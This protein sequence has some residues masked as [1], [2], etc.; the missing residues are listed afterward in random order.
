LLGVVAAAVDTNSQQVLHEG[1]LRPR[2][3]LR[4]RAW[5][6]QRLNHTDP[7]QAARRRGCSAIPAAVG[8]PNQTGASLAASSCG[9]SVEPST[10]CTCRCYA[11]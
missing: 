7:W 8:P 3:L 6:G 2:A 9:D 4:R 10:V 5:G 11:T 1:D